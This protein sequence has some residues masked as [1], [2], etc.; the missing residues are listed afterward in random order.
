KVGIGAQKPL[1]IKSKTAGEIHGQGGL[2]NFI[3][4]PS[5][6]PFDGYAWDI[7]RDEAIAAK[8][9][10]EIVTLGPLTNIAIT[11]LRYPEIK[12]LIKRIVCMAGSGYMG[13]MNAY[14]EFNAW[15]DPDACEIVLNSGVPI[16]LCPL[17]G[18]E[19]C[20]LTVD[21]LKE[22]IGK[23]TKQSDIIDHIFEFFIHRRGEPGQKDN[24][25][26]INDAVTMAYLINENIGTTKDMYVAVETKG[27]LCTGQTIVDRLNK[28]KKQPN[29][30][31]LLSSSKEVFKQMLDDMMVFYK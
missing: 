16:V 4:P 24:N 31:V 10:L 28:Y 14:A 12:P 8:G 15:V 7:I 3:L 13:N 2:A 29:A 21:E 25:Q 9:A 18:N 19:P 6:K 27:T 17:D 26:V 20:G 11:L 5:N 23:G 30:Q 1:F 22:Y